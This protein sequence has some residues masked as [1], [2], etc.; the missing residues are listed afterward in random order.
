MFLDNTVENR[1]LSTFKLDECVYVDKEFC[2]EVQRRRSR[3]CSVCVSD[4]LCQTE[5][6]FGVRFRLRWEWWQVRR[7]VD[8]KGCLAFMIV[9]VARPWRCLRTPHITGF[10]FVGSMTTFY[11]NT[12]LQ[13]VR[14]RQMSALGH[15]QNI[16]LYSVMR[17]CIHKS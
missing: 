1:K 17:K 8:H 3:R 11:P 6:P 9:H 5:L 16:Q 12:S 13:H 4:Q 10:H 14:K 7:D 15:L 2:E